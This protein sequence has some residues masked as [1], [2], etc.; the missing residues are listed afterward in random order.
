MAILVQNNFCIAPF[1]QITLSPAGSYSP[2]P[3]IGGRP[4]RDSDRNPVSMW[5]SEEFQTLRTSFLQNKKSQIC[6]RCWDQEANAKQSLRKRLLSNNPKGGARFAKGELLTFLE[7][8]YKEGPKQINL[9][10][11]NLCNL[12]CRT[13]RASSSVTYNV[14]G[15]YY[16]NKNN[17]SKIPYITRSN[18]TELFSSEQIDQIFEISKNLQRIEFYGG[19]PLLDVPTLYLLEKLIESG[20]SKKIVLFYNTNG[21]VVPTKKQYDLWNQFS[22]IEFNISID[23]VHTRYNYNRHPAIWKD[24][25]DNIN[26]MRAYNWSIPVDFFSIC[27]ISNLNVYYLPEILEE[28]SQLDLKVFLNHVYDPHWYAIQHLPIPVKNQII[29]KLTDCKQNKQVEFVINMLHSP[30]N[31]DYWTEFKFWTKEKDSYRKESFAETYPE[32]YAILHKYDNT[33]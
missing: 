12:R 11:G 6:N 23:D 32:F 10:V 8:G 24:L 4:W 28:L 9:M 21:T 19:E 1:T 30:E 18:K 2:C 25:V 3:E 33:F 29:E 26:S 16:K 31:L 27:T 20:Q 15:R 22:S 13:C 14:E 7:H 5:S 17:L